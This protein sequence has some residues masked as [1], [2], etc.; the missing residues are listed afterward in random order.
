MCKNIDDEFAKIV[1]ACSDLNGYSSSPH[2]PFETEINENDAELAIRKVT[3]I[4]DFV[5]KN[6]NIK[7]RYLCSTIY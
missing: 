1:P 2:Y 7:Q 4:L 3:S 5:T 6:G